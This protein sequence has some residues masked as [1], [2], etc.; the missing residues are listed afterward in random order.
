M[1]LVAN[2]LFDR[3]KAEPG[4][5][6][7]WQVREMRE[8]HHEIVRRLLL[9]QKNVDIANALNITPQQVSNVRN[10]E[11]V[12]DQL[13]IMRKA[14]DADSIDVAKDLAEL[15]PRAVK[16][17]KECLDNEELS[18]HTKLR[19]ADT[20]LD[21]TGHPR[22][23]KLTG[24]IKHAHAHVTAQDIEEIKARVQKAIDV[25]PE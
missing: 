1:S 15:G 17:Y 19:V 12:Q 24:N 3:R 16:I 2:A 21:R 25:T 18:L 9:G 14:R 4:E 11:V 23:Q 10:S 5:K 22:M 20:V 8:I 7:S 13:A 6:K